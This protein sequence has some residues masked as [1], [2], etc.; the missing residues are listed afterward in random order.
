[1]ILIVANIVVSALNQ[2]SQIYMPNLID[3]DSVRII[4]IFIGMLYMAHE[5]THG[6]VMV[7][8]SIGAL[9][10]ASLL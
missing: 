8:K 7:T 9:L 10:V 1:M 2:L 3:I 4:D 6:M 5:Y